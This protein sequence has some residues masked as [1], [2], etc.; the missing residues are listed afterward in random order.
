MA[1]GLD[2]REHVGN[3]SIA[4][5]EKRRTGDSHVRL[6]HEG[7]LAPDAEG[8]CDHMVGI[9]QQGKRQVELAAELALRGL[10]VG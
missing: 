8:I 10:F 1:F 5:D 2:L 4:P 6:A 9:R 7:L 3:F